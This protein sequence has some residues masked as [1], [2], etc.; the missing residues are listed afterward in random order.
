MLVFD[1]AELLPFGFFLTIEGEKTVYGCEVRH[2]F[3]ERV[4]VAFVDIS[5]IVATNPNS[6]IAPNA[7]QHKI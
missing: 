6:W 4:G 1:R 3:G 5:L 7:T 2:H